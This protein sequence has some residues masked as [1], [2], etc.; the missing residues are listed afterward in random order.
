M[1]DVVQEGLVSQSV[2]IITPPVIA[3]R[4]LVELNRGVTRLSGRGAY[5]GEPREL[6]LCVVNRLQVAQLK[7][8][9][10]EGDPEAFFII[11]SA[12]EVHGEGFRRLSP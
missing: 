8:I 12:N 9:V 2:L 5:T 4:L 7:T 10:Q 11:G 6:L 3:D 1:I